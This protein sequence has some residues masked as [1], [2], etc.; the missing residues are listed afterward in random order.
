MRQSVCSILILLLVLL[1]ASAMTAQTASGEGAKLEPRNRFGLSRPL[2]RKPGTIRLAS[3]NLLNLFDDKDDPAL[4]GEFDDIGMATT[5]ERSRTL[6]RVIKAVD[7]DILALQEVESL[8]ALLWFRDTYMPEAGYKYVASHDVGH[9]RGIEQSVMSR[10]PITHSQVWLNVSLDDVAR[11][12]SGWGSVPRTF[13]TG[14]KFRRSP[15]R[16]D[17]KVNEEYKLSIFNVHH[18]SGCDFR[19]HREAESLKIIELINQLQREDPD[20][21]IIVAGD[22]N[23]VPGEKSLRVYLEAGLID[24]LSVRTI[25]H[26]SEAPQA[27]ARLYKSHES[28]RVLDYILLNS[29]AHR[30]LVMGSAHIH[31]TL[32][33]ENYDW[34]KN[35]YPEGYA[36]DHYPVI[37]DLIPSDV[38]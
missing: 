33:V 24:T 32:Y 15:L 11:V 21:N 20:R 5:H 23:A 8:E 29:A 34:M 26:R 4:Q 12:G 7:A 1:R 22:F 3:Y 16:V 13:R 27:N 30:E 14:L 17:I 28:G 36:S 38:P 9:Y 10:F 25:S 18:K 37:I 35:P 2:P 6:A 19:F 31:G